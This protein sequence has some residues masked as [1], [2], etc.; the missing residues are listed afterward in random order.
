[1]FRLATTGGVCSA[2]IIHFN[3]CDATAWAHNLREQSGPPARAA[4]ISAKNRTSFV[5]ITLQAVIQ[6]TCRRR[7]VVRVC[8]LPQARFGT[9][10][11]VI[12][13]VVVPDLSAIQGEPELHVAVESSL[14]VRQTLRSTFLAGVSEVLG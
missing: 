3:T 13:S 9:S 10:L 4:C 14:H 6:F 11:A 7:T 12:N 2:W 8:E 5:F 1:V